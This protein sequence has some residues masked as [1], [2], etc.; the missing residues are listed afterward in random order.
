[1]LPQGY[2]KNAGFACFEVFQKI[3]DDL[4]SHS[5]EVIQLCSK[6]KGLQ[7]FAK[8]SVTIP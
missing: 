3:I 4:K 7:L 1:M 2:Y 8:D 5:E 6:R